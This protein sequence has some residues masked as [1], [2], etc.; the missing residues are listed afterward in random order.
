MLNIPGI[1]EICEHKDLRAVLP[2]M[3]E[4]LWMWAQGRLCGGTKV[5]YFKQFSSHLE[6]QAL[7]QRHG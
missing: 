2:E 4:W 1:L 7:N 3:Q 6:R 5:S